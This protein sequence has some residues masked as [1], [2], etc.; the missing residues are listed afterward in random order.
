MSRRS[1]ICASSKRRLWQNSYQ[2][3]KKSN[4]FLQ[5][6]AYIELLH[7]HEDD[8][9]CVFILQAQ[10]PGSLLVSAMF[11]DNLIWLTIIGST[12]G[13]YQAH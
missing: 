6:I 2:E 5:T 7:A 12:F 8:L 10:G 13:V 9:L 11:G 1:L 4:L 3:G